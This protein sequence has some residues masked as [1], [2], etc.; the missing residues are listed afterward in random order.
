MAETH[1]TVIGIYRSHGH[2]RDSRPD[3]PAIAA[4]T[5]RFNSAQPSLTGLHARRVRAGPYVGRARVLDCG[6]RLSAGTSGEDTADASAVDDLSARSTAGRA[7]RC[8]VPASRPIGGTGPL[9]ADRR[10]SDHHPRQRTHRSPLLRN[11]LLPPPATGT[12]GGLRHKWWL[13]PIYAGS[14]AVTARLQRSCRSSGIRPSTA[15][16][17]ITHHATRNAAI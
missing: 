7:E 8:V 2:D 16:T 15:I 10:A 11:P 3:R 1:F 6:H 17:A 12:S 9:G 14:I 13:R 5:H 4:R